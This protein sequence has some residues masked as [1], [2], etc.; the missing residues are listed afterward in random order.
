[1][2]FRPSLPPVS[3][4]TTRIRPL[5]LAPA[6]AATARAVRARNSGT[7]APQASREDVPRRS[8]SRRDRFMSG[9]QVG[10]LGALCAE[11]RLGLGQLVLRTMHDHL[12]CLPQPVGAPV[13]PGPQDHRAGL[14]V[15]RAL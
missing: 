7:P 9:L 15:T 10:P 4:T 3:C 11:R 14:V 8:R 1:M 6:S 12:Q 2:V 5:A 13:A